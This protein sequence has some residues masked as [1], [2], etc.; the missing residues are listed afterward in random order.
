LSVETLV[1]EAKIRLD[2]VGHDDQ[3]Y[4]KKLYHVT[5]DLKPYRLNQLETMEKNSFLD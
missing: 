4:D 1:T 3:I 2:E 5:A